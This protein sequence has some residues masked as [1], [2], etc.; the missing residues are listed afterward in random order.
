MPNIEPCQE[1]TKVDCPCC[2][3]EGAHIYGKGP[4]EDEYTC[5]TCDGEGFLHV[6]NKPREKVM[7][8]HTAS[9][10]RSAWSTETFWR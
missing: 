1:L 10:L 8:E 9:L 6:S 2:A 3:G 4:D 5:Q 7:A